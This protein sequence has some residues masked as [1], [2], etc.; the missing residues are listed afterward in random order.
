VPAEFG[1]TEYANCLAAVIDAVELAPAH[2]AG[3][4]WAAQSSWSST[5]TI[6]S[7]WR[8]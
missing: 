4:S 1:L 7:L 6:P 2:V 3:I 5:A 8:P